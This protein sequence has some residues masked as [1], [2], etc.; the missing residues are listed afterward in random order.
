MIL[1]NKS[2]YRVES[3]YNK[4]ILNGPFLSVDFHIRVIFISVKQGSCMYE[5]SRLNVE[6]EL[7]STIQ[8]MCDLPFAFNLFTYVHF[9][10]VYVSNTAHCS[11]H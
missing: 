11:T 8:F 1:K 3:R 10:C 5:R 2:V 4:Y 9:T 6:V 7:G